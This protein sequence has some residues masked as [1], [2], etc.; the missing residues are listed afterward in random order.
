MRFDRSDSQHRRSTDDLTDN[1]GPRNTEP[2]ADKRQDAACGRVINSTYVF[3][4]V[5][6]CDSQSTKGG[7]RIVFVTFVSPT[8]LTKNVRSA[9]NSDGAR[10]MPLWRVAFLDAQRSIA[11]SVFRA[12]SSSRPHAAT[13][14][15]DCCISAQETASRYEHL[16]TATS[17][18]KYRLQCVVR[19]QGLPAGTRTHVCTERH[20]LTKRPNHSTSGSAR[21][22]DS[23]NPDD[24]HDGPYAAHLQ[25]EK[26]DTLSFL[27]DE[28]LTA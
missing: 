11:P 14:F 19:L 12:P 16:Q 28:Q 21:D 20:R 9:L 25:W 23:P 26:A 13:C 10:S 22:A 24:P 2:S 5:Y 3:A 17:D 27:V 7:S 6:F 18:R 8:T 4:V 1:G 15:T